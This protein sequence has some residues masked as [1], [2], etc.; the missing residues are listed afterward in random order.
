MPPRSD[1]APAACRAAEKIALATIPRD[2]DRSVPASWRPCSP[3]RRCPRDLL[4]PGFARCHL[5]ETCASGGLAQLW[6]SQQNKLPGVLWLGETRRGTMRA[7]SIL[8][9]G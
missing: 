3:P 1:D 6:K 9:V 7:A 8:D 4:W 2:L 5:R